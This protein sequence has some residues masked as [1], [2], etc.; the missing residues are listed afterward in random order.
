MKNLAAI[1]DKLRNGNPNNRITAISDNMVYI[2]E[3]KDLVRWDDENSMVYAL[4]N[5]EDHRDTLRPFKIQVTEYDTIQ[6]LEVTSD[7]NGIKGPIQAFGF[8]SE[9]AD[10][11]VKNLTT[12]KL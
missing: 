10:E 5:N 2:D 3:T 8:D 1:R 4:R 11:F 9:K 12:I 7:K 6:Y